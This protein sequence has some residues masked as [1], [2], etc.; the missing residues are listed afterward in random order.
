MQALGRDNVAEPEFEV[1]ALP[2]IVE[3]YFFLR[4]VRHKVLAIVV[5]LERLN[6]FAPSSGPGV[7]YEHHRA[8]SFVWLSFL[9]VFELLSTFHFRCQFQYDCKAE[10]CFVWPV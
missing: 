10:L 9:L 1:L 5:W 3:R 6:A 4:P 8:F 2:S 7:H